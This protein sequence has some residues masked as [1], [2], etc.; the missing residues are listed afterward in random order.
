[1]LNIIIFGS[2]GA[3]KGTQAELIVLEYKLTHLS[4]GEIL[5]R[6]SQNSE[7]GN[8][9]KKYQNA[10][11]LVPNDLVIKMVNEEIKKNLLGAGFVFDGYPRNIKQAKALDKIFKDKEKTIDLV[12]NLHLSEREAIQRIIVRSHTSGRS[13]DNLKTIENRFLAYRTQTTPLLKYYRTQKKVITVDGR[14]TITAISK[15]IKKILD[16]YKN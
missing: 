5:R 3:G 8:K 13:D 7:F 16:T 15:Q 12:L 9:I 2:P 6:E 11:K 1:M 14:L 4:S 10:G